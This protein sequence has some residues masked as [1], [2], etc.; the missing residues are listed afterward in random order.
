MALSMITLASFAV[1]SG[2]EI[3][4]KTYGDDPEHGYVSIR[5]RAS[6]ITLT[7]DQTSALRLYNAVWAL[8]AEMDSVCLDAM[9]EEA[10]T[11]K[12]GV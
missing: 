7:L 10:T 12:T 1:P 3:V 6:M 5:D 2:A 9:K 4:A 8:L 11:S